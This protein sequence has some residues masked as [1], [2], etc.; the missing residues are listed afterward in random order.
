MGPGNR[1]ATVGLLETHSSE[2]FKD[3]GPSAWAPERRL[4][5]ASQT[6]RIPRRGKGTPWGIFSISSSR[7]GLINP[8]NV[9][10]GRIVFQRGPSLILSRA[11][12]PSVLRGALP[13]VFRPPHTSQGKRIGWVGVGGINQGRKDRVMSHQS[14]SIKYMTRWD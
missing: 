13:P 4:P 6:P 12:P 2:R 9:L 3:G 1:E 8:H 14:Q 10:S 5:V 11:P 7:K